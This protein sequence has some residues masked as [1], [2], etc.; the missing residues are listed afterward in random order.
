MLDNKHIWSSITT[1]I[2]VLDDDDCSCD[3]SRIV[4]ISVS[5]ICGFVAQHSMLNSFQVSRHVVR[6]RSSLS[7]WDSYSLG[8]GTRFAVDSMD[9]TY[10]PHVMSISLGIKICIAIG[11]ARP[12][13]FGPCDIVPHR[14]AVE[15]AN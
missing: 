13:L 3:C 2:N 4:Q 9:A 1:S 5:T 10:L 15:G 8:I 11:I 7:R 6:G 12:E 14:I